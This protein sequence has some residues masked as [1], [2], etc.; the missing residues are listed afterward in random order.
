MRSVRREFSAVRDTF[1]AR[2]S[3]ASA[4]LAAISPSSWPMYSVTSQLRITV[5]EAIFVYL[6]FAIEKHVQRPYYEVGDALYC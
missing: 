6:F 3:S 4:H 1:L 5:Q 2:K